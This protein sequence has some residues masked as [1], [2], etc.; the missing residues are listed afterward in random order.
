MSPEE[1]LSK[2]P[3]EVLDSAN[4]AFTEICIQLKKHC[5]MLANFEEESKAHKMS[6]KAYKQTMTSLIKMMLDFLMERV[7]EIPAFLYIIDEKLSAIHLD[8]DG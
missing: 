8:E 2:L 1:T 4:L 3:K 7:E 6:D 5:L